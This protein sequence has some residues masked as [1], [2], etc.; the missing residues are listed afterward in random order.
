MD[1][2]FAVGDHVFLSSKYLKAIRPKKKLDY[3]FRGLF[4]ILSRKG[5]RVYEL[6]LLEGSIIYNIFHISLLEQYYSP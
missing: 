1:K 6:E 4:T 5:T 2:E 3:K